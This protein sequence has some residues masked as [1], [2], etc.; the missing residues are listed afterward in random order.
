MTSTQFHRD[1]G[2][3]V[4][5]TVLAIPAFGQVFTVARDDDMLRTIDPATAATTSALIMT[6]AGST[7]Q[8]ANG[9][10]IDPS[11]GLFYAVLKCERRSKSAAV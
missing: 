10:A 1:L 3:F 2:A 7:I 4:L 11:S 6:L 5:T 8:G 9:L